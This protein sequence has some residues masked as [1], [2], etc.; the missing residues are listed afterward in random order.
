MQG[1]L[2]DPEATGAALVEGEWLRTG[3]IARVDGDGVWWIV[4]RL[5]E[6]I[7]YKGYQVAPAE[8][9]AVLMEHPAVADAAVVGIP[10]DVAGEIPKAWVV[11]SRPVT[12][13]ELMAWAAERTAPY[14]RI[15][16]VEFVDALPKSPTGKV[17]RRVLRAG[18]G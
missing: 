13:G 12:G 18:G 11:A 1:Y 15:R 16:A 7:K 8:L 6:L 3:D 4:D 14:K 10:D 2:D 9:E 17:L 5:K